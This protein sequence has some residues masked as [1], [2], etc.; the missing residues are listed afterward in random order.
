MT[1]VTVPTV[2]TAA[3]GVLLCW[4][5]Y[6]AAVKRPKLTIDDKTRAGQLRPV[7]AKLTPLH[8]KLGKPRPG[9]W[10]ARFKEPGQT[11]DEYLRCR[12]VLPR[13]KRRTIY[14]QPLG[15]LTKTQRKVI[16]L[17]G[18]FMGLYFN[19][20]VKIKKDLPLRLIPDKARRTHP[21]WGDRQI[22]STHVLDKVLKPRLP[23]DAAV[24]IA[25]TASDLWPGKGWN[26]VFGQA[27]L[28]DRVGVWSIYRNGDPDKSDKAFR[29]CL[30]RTMKTATHETGHMFSML[31]CIA[32]ECNMCG[33]NSRTESDRRPL[34]LCPQCLAKVCWA[35]GTDP[36]ERFKA[37]TKF[38][39]KHKLKAEADFYDKCIKV[40]TPAPKRK[41]NDN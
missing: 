7:I 21:T 16:T 24:Y 23:G 1:Y 37:L 26:F 35:T 40:L 28:V 22:L 34:A 2:A 30:L 27:S 9:D 17:T 4:S 38:C 29:L 5:L 39:T 18:Q 6:A 10:L 20:P 15:D 25:L 14:V 31:H 19:L 12:P 11:F 8:K 33:S 32:C 13:G 36:L 3:A 41:T